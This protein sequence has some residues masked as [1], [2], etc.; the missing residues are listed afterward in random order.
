MRKV[1]FILKSK[2]FRVYMSLGRGEERSRNQRMAKVGECTRKATFL[3]EEQL[4][5]KGNIILEWNNGGHFSDLLS[6]FKKALLW[7]M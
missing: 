3:L 1:L 2:V 7:L 6:R 4:E 5:F